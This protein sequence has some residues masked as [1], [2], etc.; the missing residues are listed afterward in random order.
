MDTNRQNESINSGY[1]MGHSDNEVARLQLQ[2]TILA[3]ITR[4]LLNE[5]GLRP[6]MRVLDIG[7]GTGDVSAMMA[8]IVGKEGSVVGI[9][10]NEIAIQ[11]S[12]RRH[13]AGAHVRFEVAALEDLHD[14]QPFDLAFGRYILMH[15]PDPSH[16]VRAAASILRPGGTLA[17]H[18]IILLDG[19]PASPQSPLWQQMNSFF[20]GAFQNRLKHVNIAS[21][22]VACFA[23]AGLRAPK[24]FSECIVEDAA[25]SPV[26]SWFAE[27]LRTLEQDLVAL[28]GITEAELDINTLVDRLTAEARCY[29][30]QVFS[31]RQVAAWVRVPNDGILLPH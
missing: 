16:M 18:E 27:T 30:T 6:G 25:T 22:L 12:R 28:F 21:Q 1:L 26:T 10:R 2:S 11:T 14:V 24:L 19:F 13:V 5:V 8:D 31:S 20:I 23:A 7:C 15:Q 4:R 9:D 17:F 29:N 3:P